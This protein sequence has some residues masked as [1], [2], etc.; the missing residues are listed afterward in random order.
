MSLNTKKERSPFNLKLVYI[1][2][3]KPQNKFSN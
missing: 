2:L 3:L 1:C